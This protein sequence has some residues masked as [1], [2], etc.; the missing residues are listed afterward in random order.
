M[1]STVP[2]KAPAVTI[3]GYSHVAVMVDDLDAA[4]TF[5]CDTLGFSKL[6]RPDFGPGTEG[7]WLQL[8]T[9]QVHLGTVGD[10]GSR[11]GFPHIAL[12]VPANAWD[13]TMDELA[14]RGV[15]FVMGPNAREDFGRPVRAAF[16]QDPAGNFIELTDVDPT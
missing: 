2:T 1:E 3:A 14:A 5:Y 4:I 6:P 8:G 10:M 11:V 15:P 12:H 9:A 7:V 13:T 16:I